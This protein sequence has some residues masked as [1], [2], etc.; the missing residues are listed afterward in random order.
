VRIVAVAYM[1][2]PCIGILLSFLSGVGDTIPVM[3]IEI[4]HM[5]VI[6]VPLAYLIPRFTSMGVYGVRW[7]MVIG[8][9]A[10]ASAMLIY[11]IKGRWKLKRV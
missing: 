5:W 10:G 4:G 11:F 6:M 3:I 2:F 8:V 7:A 1:I 9:F